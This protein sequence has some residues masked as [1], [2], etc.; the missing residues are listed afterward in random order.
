MTQIITNIDLAVNEIL[1]GNVVALP[2]ETVYGLGANALNV[3]AVIKIYETKDRPKFNP[4]IVHV[5]DVNDLQKYADNIPE[6]VYRLAEKFSPGPLTFVLK[7]K[8]IIPDIV[9]AGNESVGLRIPSHKLFREVLKA[10]KLPVAAPSANRAGRISPTSAADVMSELNGKINYILDGGKS[11]I[12]IESTI[13]SFLDDEIKILRHGYVTKEDIEK[14]TGKISDGVTDKI[15]SPGLL[16]THYAP[17]TPLYI[18]ENFE[19]VK[20]NNGK[21]IGILD[22]SKY[23]DSKEIALNLFSDLRKLDEMN[24]DYIVAKKVEDKGLGIAINDRLMRA[25]SNE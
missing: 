20:N 18:T 4:V 22:F 12:G 15:I 23:K 6:A 7:K 24:F 16:K 8:N 19:K 17:R 2:T 25:M 1:T 14:V 3:N 11:E 5:Y 10:S 9:T 21:K 13:I